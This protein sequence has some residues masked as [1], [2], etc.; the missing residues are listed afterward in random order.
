MAGRLHKWVGTAY[1]TLFDNEDDT[2]SMERFQVFDFEAMRDI[3]RYSS[4]SC[5]TCF[6]D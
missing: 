5:S 4:L 3:R 1:A 6:V 2:I